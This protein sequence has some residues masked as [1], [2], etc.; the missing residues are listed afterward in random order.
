MGVFVVVIVRGIQS[1]LCN[2]VKK[3]KKMLR[4]LPYWA[5]VT[6][7]NERTIENIV[8]FLGFVSIKINNTFP[9]KYRI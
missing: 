4:E 5:Y 1:S 2:K 3:E 6:S 7:L 8:E 9:R